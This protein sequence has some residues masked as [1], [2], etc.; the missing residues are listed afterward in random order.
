MEERREEMMR[1]MD[2][3]VKLAHDC[4]NPGGSSYHNLDKLIIIIVAVV[5]TCLT[6]HNFRGEIVV[7]VC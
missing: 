2:R 1:S 6:F 5:F 7:T 4:V 3:I